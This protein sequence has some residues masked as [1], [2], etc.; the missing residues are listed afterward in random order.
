MGLLPLLGE[1]PGC[2]LRLLKHCP[3][4]PLTVPLGTLAG[5]LVSSRPVVGTKQCSG[6]WADDRI[7]W[8]CLGPKP[9][10]FHGTAFQ[11]VQ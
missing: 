7:P 4:V 6:S 5:G 9:T 1:S 8:P 2:C 11:A 3:T 10:Y